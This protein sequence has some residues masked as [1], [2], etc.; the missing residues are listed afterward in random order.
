M[1]IKNEDEGAG[2]IITGGG[3]SM[4]DPYSLENELI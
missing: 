3:T 2:A 1:Q 4:L